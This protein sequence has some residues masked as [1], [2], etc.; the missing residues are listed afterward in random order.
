M[1]TTFLIIL[2]ALSYS[3]ALG[4]LHSST[5]NIVDDDEFIEVEKEVSFDYS[6]LQKSVQYP[7]LAKRANIQG[8][9][10]VKVYVDS[11]G[12]PV[13]HKILQSD[14]EL[15]N[16][17][18]IDA[19]MNFDEFKPAIQK[20][21]HVGMW[22]SIPFHFRKTKYFFRISDI[23]NTDNII[24]KSNLEVYL[25]ENLG[26]KSYWERRKSANLEL[27]IQKGKAIKAKVID[28]EIEQIESILESIYKYDGFDV[29]DEEVKVK[30]T[31]SVN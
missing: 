23:S 17:A 7:D 21:K 1:K 26:N 31:I 9:V 16:E 24:Y 22:I 13:K 20:G 29:R 10:V 8:I 3:F 6:R 15:F 14:N 25:N 28:S 18:A 5:I 19:I 30:L 2:I 12:K 4:G 11:T 27:L